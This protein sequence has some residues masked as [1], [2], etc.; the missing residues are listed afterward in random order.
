M[1][2]IKLLRLSSFLLLL[3]LLSSCASGLIVPN[4]YEKL[5]DTKNVAPV[6]PEL[7]NVPPLKE[8][9]ISFLAAGDN[10]I[11]DGIF[12]DAKRRATANSYEY[13]FAPIYEDVADLIKNADI[14]F[15]NQETPMGGAELG[16]SGYPN[17]N[18]PQDL[19]RT[20]V[21]IGFD[22]INIA[23]NHMLDKWE[24]GLANTIKFWES[25]PVLLLGGYKDKEDYDNIRVLEYDGVKI[26]F[27]SYTYSKKDLGTNGML[28]PANS[29]YVIPYADDADII[30]R[31]GLA[32]ETGADLIFA[33]MHWGIE[34]DFKPS[35]EQRRLARLLADNG[36]DVII[37]HH[38]HVLQP[39]EWLDRPDGERTLVIY[40]LGNLLSM[41]SNGINMLGGFAT[42]DIVQY[43][44]DKPYIDNVSFIPTICHFD[45][46]FRNCKIYL[47]EDYSESLGP[48]HGTYNYNTYYNRVLY[49]YFTLDRAKKWLTDTI[50][51]AYLPVSVVNSQK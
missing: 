47:L 48:L 4:Q 14:A 6:D 17:F 10:L 36:V 9:R 7:D 11:H 35:S 37:G 32:K 15:I 38:P 8:K 1:C 26:A 46:S 13:N 29:P 5:P 27:I 43:G 33:S 51:S 31:L 45:Q 3:I 28:L 39:I 44:F 12:H 24:I 16:Y 22:I 34:N 41:M 20:L 23:N 19:G 18:S 50:A 40:S 2:N 49:G 42:F 21:D 25:Q 30:R